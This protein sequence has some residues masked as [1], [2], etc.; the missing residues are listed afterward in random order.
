MAWFAAIPGIV[1]VPVLQKAPVEWFLTNWSK[2]WLVLGAKLPVGLPSAENAAGHAALLEFPPRPANTTAPQLPMVALP[3]LKFTVPVGCPLLA[4]D[5]VAVNVV[6]L[7]G[8]PVND[9][10]TEELS[11]VVVVELVNEAP[12]VR[13]QELNET[14]SLISWSTT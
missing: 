12:K 3:S 8:A 4:V 10:S 5:T 9:G 14:L 11:V 7:L 1:I 6:E 13:V 2:G